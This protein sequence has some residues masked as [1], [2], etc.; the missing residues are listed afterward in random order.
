[1]YMKAEGIAKSLGGTIIFENLT[2]DVNA[3]EH[4]ALVGRN[5]CGKTTLLRLLAGED[6]PDSGRIIRAKDSTVGFLH[7]IP[8]YPG[9]TVKEVMLKAFSGLLAVEKRMKEL[10]SRM[11]EEVTDRILRQY[12]EL[13]E[14]FMEQG[15]YEMESRLLSIA[16]GLG[17]TR[18][19]DQ[20]FDLLS[21]GEKTKVMLGRIL[22]QQPDILLLDEPTNHLDLSAIEWLEQHVQQFPGTVILV[23]HDREFMNRA[24]GKVIELE[25]GEC[26]VSRGDYDQFLL[27]REAR[28]AQQFSAYQEQQ[29]K[30]KKIKEA[31]RRLR[32]WANEASPPNPDL[33]RK[34]KSMEKMLTR[35]EVVRKPKAEK[36]MRLHLDASDRSGK[37]VISMEALSHS[38][39]DESYVLAD[40]S[41]AVHWQDRLAIVGNNGSG[42]STLLKL[43][44]GELAPSEG[45]VRLGSNVKAGYLAQQF[46]TAEGDQRLIEAFREDI[47]MTEADARHVLAQFLFYGHD[48]YKKVK[49]LSGGERM[50]LRLAQLMQ[51]D[52]NLLILDE[53]TN[54]LDIE[55]REVLE[56]TLAQ[57]SGTLVAVSHD[58]YFLQ[59][60]FTTV[61]WVEAG[62]VTVHAGDY[63]F[64]RRKQLALRG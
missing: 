46:G 16:N 3:G 26:W 28:L 5:G 12:G 47:A 11:A 63:T 23:S 61:A 36:A 27:N 1:M 48:V 24:A 53:P 45:T 34:A 33:Y 13:Q 30:I 64:A 50:R 10:E 9:Q 8:S 21:G 54:H 35:M 43:M 59:K 38:F 22:L 19:L 17:I 37:E 52:L 57:F 51:E 31:I 42:K 2:M 7:Q 29:K 32:Q 14:S 25:D 58:R 60:L 4:V 6:T 56:E 62:T 39:D 44:L 41:L 40:C 18:F 15:G 55:S 49:D 20:P